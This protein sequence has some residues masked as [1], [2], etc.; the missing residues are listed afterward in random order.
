MATV[1]VLAGLVIG[2]F[3]LGTSPAR[4]AVGGLRRYSAPA[5]WSIT[6]PRAWR[7]ERSSSAADLVAYSE[8]TIANFAQQ[9]AVHVTRT[10]A[11]TSLVVGPPLDPSGRFPA[12]GVA[13]R[14]FQVQGGPPAPPGVTPDS[15]FPIELSRFRP[16]RTT[17]FPGWEGQGS[18]VPS[19]VDLQVDADGEQY[20]AVVLIGQR[21]S[22]RLRAELAHAVASLSVPPLRPGTDVNGLTV[23]G[24]ASDY[25]VGSF[26]LVHAADSDR[27]PFYLVHAPGSLARPNLAQPCPDAGACTPPG[28]FYAIGWTSPFLQGGY[29]EQCD[30]QL[31]RQDDQFYCTNMNARWDR[32]GR[33]IEQPHG[34]RFS[35][36][37]QFGFVKVA[38]DG[39]VVV[40]TDE[41]ASP[42]PAPAVRILWPTWPVVVGT[43]G[44]RWNATTMVRP[45]PLRSKP[46]AAPVTIATLRSMALAAA[47]RDGDRTPTGIDEVETTHSEALQLMEPGCCDGNPVDDTPVYVVQLIGS[48]TAYDAPIPPGAAVPTG[49]VL[50]M[51]VDANTGF[52]TDVSV[53]THPVNLAA[54]GPVTAL[55]PSTYVSSSLRASTG[56]ATGRPVGSRVEFTFRGTVTNP[57]VALAWFEYKSFASARNAFRRTPKMRLSPHLT[58]TSI[59][60]VAGWRPTPSDPA[61]LLDRL[62]VREGGHTVYGAWLSPTDYGPNGFP[63]PRPPPPPS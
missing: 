55:T 2:L 60:Q 8:F 17:D 22:P 1:S 38:W 30:L 14:I 61:G 25:P 52:G 16:P 33:V 10:G 49:T 35:D 21:A 23:L 63:V 41:L 13:F 47:A 45:D 27:T 40:I 36:P 29:A 11:D 46:R 26:T 20:T 42:P 57:T 31:D 34:A 24:P 39:R 5:G 56:S 4:A 32:V 54:A 12:D 3:G 9:R 7:L 18:G 48:F 59:D 6:Y 15:R 19:S 28:G 44:S 37:L 53:R 51:V 58:P 50:I 62:V 43:S